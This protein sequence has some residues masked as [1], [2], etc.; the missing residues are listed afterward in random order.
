[1]QRIL[2]VIPSLD[3]G[4]AARQLTLLASGLPGEE[5]TR[6]VCVLGQ[7]GSWAET[8][9]K[10]GVEVD[11]FSWRHFL[12]PRPLLALRRAMR[13]F[14]PDLIHAWHLPA[15]WPAA[16]AGLGGGARLVVSWPF[17]VRHH[18]RTLSRLDRLLLARACAVT[19]PSA[20]E[21]ERS[22]RLGLPADRIVM[23]APGIGP[24][25]TPAAGPAE[26]GLPNS[27][28]LIA[29]LG[30]LEPHK[31]FRDAVWALDI[32]RGL[33]DNLHLLL[34]GRGPERYRLEQF[35]RAVG[36]RDR[37][38][39]AGARENVGPLLAAA[40]VV[41]VPDRVEGSLDAALEAM[42]A[43]R[44]VVA[45]RL[46][47]LA[48]LVVDGE[49]GLLVPPG[50]KAALARQTRRLLDDSALRQRLGEKGR[51]RAA[52][53]FGARAMVR[54]FGEL[55]GTLGEPGASAPGGRFGC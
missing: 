50:D 10:A 25:D 53:Q 4:G 34:I 32:L 22:R 18:G 23:I 42:S 39:F 21:A 24:L 7:G 36:S 2:F 37:I 43:G 8:L 13:A 19:V 30:P 14:R 54:R 33:H 41:W 51:Q 6:R 55:Y 27:V 9:R 31:G 26:L 11:V 52:E 3:F 47:G 49:T 44:P 12:D 46:P 28:R 15:A 38:H 17:L 20:Y 29:G 5:F 48:E 40:E 45:S 16:L 35:A 1:V